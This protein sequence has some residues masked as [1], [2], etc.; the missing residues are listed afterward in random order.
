MTEV[1]A[2]SGQL[3]LQTERA[4]QPYRLLTRIGQGGMSEI[5]L[6]ESEPASGVRRLVVVKR[7]LTHIGDDAGALQMFLDEARIAVRLN[8]PNIVQTYDVGVCEGRYCIAMEYL[9]GQPL[10]RVHHRAQALSGGLPV[11]VAVAIVVEMLEGLAHAHDAVD[12]DGAPLAVVHRDIS[13][14]NVFV[15]YDGRVKV[16]DFGIAKAN[17]QESRTR[18]GLVKGK[19]GYMAPEQALAQPVDRRADVWSAGVVLWELLTGARLFK[20]NSEGATLNLTLSGEVPSVRSRRPDVPPELDAIVQ[21]ALS[22]EL[23]RRFPSAQAMK[24]ELERWLES[25]DHHLG[26]RS[27]ALVMDALFEGERRAQERA[28]YDLLARRDSTPPSS[29]GTYSSATPFASAT[30]VQEASVSLL[31]AELRRKDRLLARA[32]TSLAAFV[33]AVAAGV[34]YAVFRAPPAQGSAVAPRAA[35]LPPTAPRAAA[36]APTAPRAAAPAPTVPRAAAPAPIVPSETPKAAPAAAAP[37][38]PRNRAPALV[39][40][41]RTEKND[42]ELDVKPAPGAS[43]VEPGRL[44]IDSTPWSVV[45]TGGRVLGQTPVVG[46]VLPAGDHA[47]TLA[48]PELGLSTTYWVRVES[49]R[50]TVRRVGLE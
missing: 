47:L 13:P 45:S 38:L 44:T 29:V 19:F 36:P 23:P 26:F 18:T 35:A 41:R 22:R 14:H 25:A 27:I 40:P 46:A 1:P 48:N 20:G 34:S 16:L 50:T 5:F 21:T 28:V 9:R 33:L 37:A 31:T 8:H 10:H 42:R 7:L 2:D 17:T 30:N 39:P 49:G 24:E 32:F 12:Y 11:G 3:L 6:A 15:Q 43:A 4:F